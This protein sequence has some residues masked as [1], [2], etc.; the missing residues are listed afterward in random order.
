MPYMSAGEQYARLTL[1]EDAISASGKVQCLCRC[2]TEKA[3][4]ARSVRKG[5]SRSCG[6]LRRERAREL[7]TTHGLTDHPLYATWYLMVRR[8]TSPAD[9]VWADYGGRGIRVCDR[10]LGLEGL[11]NFVADVGEKPSPK[12]SLDRIDNDKGYR[13]DNVR[14]ATAPQQRAN[15]RPRVR[16]SQYEAALTE[17]ERLRRLVSDLGGDPDAPFHQVPLWSE[18]A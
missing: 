16:N 5:L 9:R 10:W 1:L 2:G 13:P 4:V 8:C 7:G 14:W 15:M 11:A 12:H 6:F 18:A 17:V 3:I